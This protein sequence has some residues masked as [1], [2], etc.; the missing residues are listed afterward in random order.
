MSCD[1]TITDRRN[2]GYSIYLLFALR[3]LSGTLITR[4]NFIFKFDNIKL[5][6]SDG[7]VLF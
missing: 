4:K 1:I 3:F 6:D 5:E 2:Y 7:K